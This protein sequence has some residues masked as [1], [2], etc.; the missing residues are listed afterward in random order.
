MRT[1]LWVAGLGLGLCLAGPA[2]AQSAVTFGPA[3]I[4][5]IQNH[6]VDTRNVNVPIASP[7]TISNTSFRLTSL[8]P[9]LTRMS[10]TTVFGSSTFPTPAQMSAGAPNYFKA[11]QMY[12]P[13]PTNVNPATSLL[14][15]KK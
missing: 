14:T 11:F 8:F 5:P 10:N 7:M 4:G 12:R 13:Q 3:I 1:Y 6:V 2:R 9:N 15:K